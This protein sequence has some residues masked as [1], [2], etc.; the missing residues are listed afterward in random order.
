M[1]V[2]I[3]VTASHIA[4][5]SRKSKLTGKGESIK[6]LIELCKQYIRMHVSCVFGR[7]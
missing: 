6:D 7:P 5:Y 4:I 2:T 3:D 1:P